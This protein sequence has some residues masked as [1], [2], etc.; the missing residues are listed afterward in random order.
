MFLLSFPLGWR[1]ELTSSPAVTRRLCPETGEALFRAHSRYP[2]H[3][4]RLGL[5]G[6]VHLTGVLP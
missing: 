2:S 3:N 1:P 6:K 4:Q 5:R